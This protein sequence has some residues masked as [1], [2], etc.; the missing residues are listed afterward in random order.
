MDE[1]SLDRLHVPIAAENERRPVQIASVLSDLSD[2]DTSVKTDRGLASRRH[3]P[4]GSA[5]RPLPLQVYT[6]T[7]S[8]RLAT[9]GEPRPLA[10]FHPGVAG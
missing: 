9:S 6:T 8:P 7:S 5:T 10:K 3:S 2:L 4:S 1:G